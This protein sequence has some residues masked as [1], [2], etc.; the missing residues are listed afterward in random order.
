MHEQTPSA[1]ILVPPFMQVVVCWH[2][3]RADDAEVWVFLKTSRVKGTRTAATTT[4]SVSMMM[5]T[6]AHKGSPQQVRLFF[7]GFAVKA[8]VEALFDDPWK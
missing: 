1:R 3:V 5:K 7:F 6:K 8:L 2:C 4:A